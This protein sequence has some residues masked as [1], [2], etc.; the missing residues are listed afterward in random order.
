MGLHGVCDAAPPRCSGK[1]N[2]LLT[3]QGSS[4]LAGGIGW[5]QQP[6]GSVLRFWGG[7]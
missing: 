3:S 1:M 7:P 5:P 6:I 4:C 2:G